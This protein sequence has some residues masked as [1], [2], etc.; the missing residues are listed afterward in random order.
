MAQGCDAAPSCQIMEITKKRRLSDIVL[1]FFLL[2]HPGP[3]LMHIIAVT[4]FALL[5]A[6]PHFVWGV[7]ALV[8]AAHAAMQLSIAVLNDYCDRRLDAVSKPTKPIPRGLVRPGEALFTG[9]LLIIVMVVLL[10]P[11][12]R[13]A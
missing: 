8:V 6:W 3:V 13:L 4:L 9:I 11:L 5:A 2:S 1:G 7:I 12:N 10:L